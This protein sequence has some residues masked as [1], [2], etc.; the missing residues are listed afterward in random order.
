[1]TQSLLFICIFVLTDR[2][3]LSYVLAACFLK[4]GGAAAYSSAPTHKFFVMVH[5]NL[6]NVDR[7][8]SRKL[9]ACGRYISTSYGC[10]VQYLR[11]RHDYR[12]CMYR[13]FPMMLKW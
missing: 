9:T 10:K 7:N 4:V 8:F 5:P 2:L 12:C 6:V 11:G 13:P 3:P 1:M